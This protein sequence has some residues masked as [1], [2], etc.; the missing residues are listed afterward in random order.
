MKTQGS[1]SLAEEYL[2]KNHQQSSNPQLEEDRVLAGRAKVRNTHIVLPAFNEE[3]SLPPLLRRLSGINN[4]YEGEMVAWVVDDGSNDRTADIASKGAPGLAIN[5]VSH[6]KN[7]GLGQAVMTGIMA[8]LQKAS[9]DDAVV[10]MDADDT[11]DVTV[12]E[13][14]IDLINAGGDIAVASRF[15]PGGDDSTAPLFR[16]ILSRGAAVVFK[17]ILPV[18]EIEDFTSGYRAYRAGLLRRAVRHWGE[19]LIEEQ[20]FACMVELLLK[21]RY[22][23]PVIYET[24]LVL[25]YDRKQGKSKL[26]LVKTMVQYF[27]LALRDRLSPKPLRDI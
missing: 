26:K 12:I 20:G 17:T 9:N 4:T 21:L 13:S 27:K 7:L 14:M 15:S 3:K 18:K 5:L 25:R 1:E 16:R 24:P 22:L 19:R 23:H 10:V 8:A 11:H 2:S 6:E